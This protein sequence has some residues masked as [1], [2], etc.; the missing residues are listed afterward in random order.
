MRVGL[1]D[2][3][4]KQGDKVFPNLALMRISAYHKSRG[5]DVEWFDPLMGQY[6]KVY[7]SKV[8]TFSPKYNYLPHDA[9]LGGTGY[10]VKSMLP[11][12]IED[13]PPDYSIY[14]TW[15]D[16]IAI[17]R[18]TVGCTNKCD[19]CLV[20]E[21]EPEFKPHSD[22]ETIL[23]GRKEVVLLDNNALASEWAIHELEKSATNKIKIDINQ[24]NDARMIDD[25]IAKL[26]SKMKWL[27]PVRLACDHSSQ[28]DNL[29]KAIT[30]L[31]WR[32]VTP[33]KYFCYVL[34]KEIPDAI[35]RLRFLKAMYI[36]PYAQP[37]R[38]MENTPITRDQ[39]RL[40]R[41]VNHKATFNSVWW[42]DYKK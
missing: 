16:N 38:D 31:R 13:T 7:S 5:D 33:S 17:G 21:K 25:S 28:I 42:E 23:Q 9:I 36:D 32:N 20:P 40:A 2:S 29:R 27:K 24:G 39:Q 8:F 10:D 41:W 11:K 14:P 18:L 30:L 12:E 1:H 15:D 6:D 26:F 3:D 34:I 19:W 37:Y 22:L 4:M 35:E